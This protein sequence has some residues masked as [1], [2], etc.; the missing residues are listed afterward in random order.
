MNKKQSKNAMARVWPALAMM[1]T[2]WLAGAAEGWAADLAAP[3]AKS[4]VAI[5]AT[6]D[7][8]V[9]LD[10]LAMWRCIQLQ[11]DQFARGGDGSLRQTSVSWYG[12][13]NAGGPRNLPPLRYPE[14]WTAATFE[15]GAWPRVRWPQPA[16]DGI[17]DLYYAMG[18]LTSGSFRPFDTIGLLARGKF[19]IQDPAQVKACVL[20]LKY[21]GGVVV[22]VNGKE[23]ARGHMSN[24]TTNGVT[25]AEDYPVNAFVGAN[26]IPIMPEDL[27][28]NRDRLA[29]RVRELSEVKIPGA[30]LIKGANV[31]SVEV[32]A[33]PIHEKGFRANH[34]LAAALWPPVGLLSAGLTVSPAAG[35]RAGGVRV[36][37][38]AVT[39][40]ATTFDTWNP[41][42]PLRP[43][44]IRAARNTVFSGRL[45]VDSD[46]PIKGLTATVSDLAQ[47]GGSAKISANSVRVRYAVP[48]EAAK[49]YVQPPYFDGLLDTIPAVVPVA[50]PSDLARPFFGGWT[51][52]WSGMVARAVAPLWFTV[53]VPRNVPAGVYEGKASVEA[54]GMAPTSVGLR[55][56]VCDWTAP[57]PKDFWMQN[58]LYHSEDAVALHYEVSRWSDRHFELMGRS[59]ALGA[60]VNSR[61][62]FVNLTYNFSGSN[63]ESLIRWIKQAD[64][65]YKH[66]FTIFDKYLNMVDKAI[67]KPRPLRLNCW[68]AVK[69]NAAK[70]TR[71]LEDWGMGEPGGVW[72]TGMNPTNGN[73]Y[74][75]V[76][77]LPGTPESLAFWRPVF[78]AILPR[79]KARGWMDETAL[80]HNSWG[81]AAV[82][83][84]VDM[85]YK[86]WPEGVWSYVSH[87]AL[88][89]E[90]FVGTQSN[91]TMIVRHCASPY[92]GGRGGKLTRPD[93]YCTTYRMFANERSAL[94]EMRRIG[95]D[96]VYKGVDGVCE[97]GLDIFPTKITDPRGGVRYAYPGG[98]RGTDWSWR[99]TMSL[100]YPGPDGPVATERYEMFR[101][102]IELSEAIRFIRKA[103]EE[104]KLG[105]EL[106]ERAKR[107]LD[108]RAKAFGEGAFDLR[109]M[110]A[111]DDAKLLDLA[112]EVAREVERKK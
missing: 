59:L 102:G 87:T 17:V 95:E 10:E 104:N 26:N 103:I 108:D 66:D 72:V 40:R 18:Y 20:S 2:I 77:P 111:S 99:S 31:V 67:G 42:E 70:N 24:I 5:P 90:K 37:N 97:F 109:H 63:G 107:Y 12:T 9:V 64:G 76:Q 49:C 112:G 33:A 83:E 51:A 84:V 3:A 73:L 8:T 4:A 38:A 79:I 69:I 85:A 13:G 65:S 39:D 96:I 50:P 71:E 41:A 22:Y 57:D 27:D 110:Q 86:L 105:V 60:E 21:W 45:M 58:F 55:V 46:Q 29:L 36:W 56:N 16:L 1:A 80:G 30:L 7:G 35:T 62:V 52:S 93:T 94:T 23:V 44:M 98:G 81:A 32:H 48:A 28:Q 6:G 88:P 53:R 82:P 74:G 92:G 54:E 14:G 78:E 89:G 91:I 75:I 68:G 101:E 43:I 11:G 34:E 100:L 15:D 19:V 106:Q 47:V 61:Q 25:L